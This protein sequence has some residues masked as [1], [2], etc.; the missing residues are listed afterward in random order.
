MSPE[1]MKEA[2]RLEHIFMPYAATRREKAITTN[3]RFVHYTSAMGALGIISS[4]RIWMRNVTCMADY[5]EVV[6]G[7]ESV[8]KFF[9]NQP[10]RNAFV[11]A[12]NRC[13]P[14]AGLEGLALF[15]QWWADTRFGS[16]IA[17][18]SE[19]EDDEDGHG[20]LSMWRAFGKV[21]ARVA[22]VFKL[23]LNEG[24]SVPLGV[25]FGP[26]AYLTEA[27]VLGELARVV[28]NINTNTEYLRSLH[29][30]RVLGLVFITLVAAVVSLKHVGFKEEREWRVIY[31]PK[32]NPS[33]LIESSIESIDGVPQTIHKLPVDGGVSA[34]L[35]SLD[36]ARMLDRVIIGPNQYALAMYESFVAALSNAG[37]EDAAHRVVTSGIPI[38]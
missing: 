38:R 16:Y 37:I 26:V 24:V 15:D 1:E 8:R 12:I 33:P 30:E 36:V 5:S 34:E 35:S 9:Q 28:A 31:S 25:L 13:S 20:R 23:P 22:L 14:G 29:R 17:C 21:S 10:S 2:Q 27:E 7:Y 6:H 3:R 19:H 32:R 4:K 18:M 11:D